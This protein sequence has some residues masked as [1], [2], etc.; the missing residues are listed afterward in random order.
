MK[1]R[2]VHVRNT[3]RSLRERVL[4]AGDRQLGAGN[5][6]WR[7]YRR[8]CRKDQPLFY[9][10]GDR[11]FTARDLA[12]QVA[13]LMTFYRSEGVE[14]GSHVGLRCTDG[15]TGFVHHVAITSLGAVAVHCNPTMPRSQA[16]AYFTA[17]AARRVFAED[18]GEG[19]SP[20]E[21]LRVSPPLLDEVPDP[22]FPSNHVIMISHSSGTT[23]TPKTPLFTHGGFFRG[24][25][26]RLLTFPQN[27]TT[28]LLTGL[29]HSHSAG[30]SYM[31]TALL[32][33]TPLYVH[34]RQSPITIEAAI[35]EFRPT[36]VL[37]FPS[38]FGDLDPWDI[39]A[40]AREG[41]RFWNG[42]G[43]ASHAGHIRRLL[44]A[45]P[46]AVYIDGLGSSEMGMVLF[47]TVKDRDTTATR[48]VGKPAPVVRDAAVFDDGGRRLPKGAPGRLGVLTPSSTPGYFANPE[49]TRQSQVGSYFL[50]GDI[51]QELE[52]GRWRHL[53]RVSDVIASPQGDLYST[54][55]EELVHE[56]IDVQDSAVVGIHD[57][58]GSLQPVVF[59]VPRETSRLSAV[60]GH[61]RITERI[62]V[63]AE[64][65][66]D[67]PRA[68]VLFEG[69]E[70]FPRGVTGKALKRVLRDEFASCLETRDVSSTPGVFDA[71]YT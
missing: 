61:T 3:H 54:L 29:P 24:K 7:S 53:D 65:G 25:R 13:A 16:E 69:I 6:F 19:W 32:T 42:M 49:M 36:G 5:F 68:V 31:S 57:R 43:D 64:P 20:L 67:S 37:S 1:V 2:E 38:T 52:D 55:M 59:A 28:R 45:C 17:A 22:R 66:T 4:L 46:N 8:L 33:G 60:E 44:R 48:I 27:R 50:T 41:L 26:G 23:G 40:E 9:T 70:H 63:A 47:Q 21:R 18:E 39:D 12:R 35:S 34:N 11:V 56:A 51:A 30:L 10:D 71:Y 58:D 15:V 14:R 62:N